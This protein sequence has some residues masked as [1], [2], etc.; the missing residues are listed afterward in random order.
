M[1]YIELI[2]QV[3][4]ELF[5]GEARV[6]VRLS[7]VHLEAD[8]A[9]ALV[10]FARRT[11]GDRAF[12]AVAVPG[13]AEAEGERWCF[14]SG[15]RAAEMATSWRNRVRTEVGERVLYVSATRLGEEGGL[16][17]V[18]S[19]RWRRGPGGI[20]A[21]TASRAGTRPP[22]GPRRAPH[23]VHQQPRR[24]PSGYAR[25][26]T[27][28][29][30]GVTVELPLE[31]GLLPAEDLAARLR[32]LWVLDEVRE[33]RMTRVRAAHLLGF[34]LDELLEVVIPRTVWGELVER[35]PDAPGVEHLRAATWVKVSD[36]AEHL[37]SV[38][39]AIRE[40]EASGF[41]IAAPLVRQVLAHVGEGGG[42]GE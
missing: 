41:R 6:G 5:D 30:T 18:L 28:P 8:E 34:T 11:M 42:A 20:D 21:R 4:G 39:A 12:V 22:P 33:G 32:L 26:M 37:P 25:G 13:A 3:A 19:G 2:C 36:L 14:S 24:P 31:P 16:V 23:Q 7:P 35:R 15:G 27:V 29:A 9:H 1:K 38:E 10:E 40:L 17:D